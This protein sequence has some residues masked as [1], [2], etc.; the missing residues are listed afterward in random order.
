VNKKGK[1]IKDI[2]IEYLV[3]WYS[4]FPSLGKISDKDISNIA[5]FISTKDIPSGWKWVCIPNLNFFGE[6]PRAVQMM[7]NVS[8]KRL[9]T[10]KTLT[11]I[12]QKDEK[13]LAMVKNVL[14]FQ[15]NNHF[16]IFPF[17]LEEGGADKTGKFFLG[18]FELGLISISE[19]HK[20]FDNNVEI[21]CGGNYF[22]YDKGI[23]FIGRTPAGISFRSKDS[24]P[25][26]VAMGFKIF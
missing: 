22:L 15:N 25:D 23:P 7:I 9:R 20:I 24:E 4:L 3:L 13:K 6:Y 17:R 19:E 16:S 1:I 12:V 26:K 21:V 10:E 2:L 11:H 18:F 5:E 8:N 14:N